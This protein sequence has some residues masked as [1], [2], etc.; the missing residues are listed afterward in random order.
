MEQLSEGHTTRKGRAENQNQTYL[1][2]EYTIS[3]AAT[4]YFIKCSDLFQAR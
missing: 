2:P 1:T 3:I 4:W